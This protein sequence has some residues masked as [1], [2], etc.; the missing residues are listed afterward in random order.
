MQ[1]RG[2]TSVRPSMKA[3]DGW[4]GVSCASTGDAPWASWSPLGF[5]RLWWQTC[6]VTPDRVRACLFRSFFA[7]IKELL[8]LL[9]LLVLPRHRGNRL[10]LP[11]RV[12][13]PLQFVL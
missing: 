6:G 7:M 5:P 3:D 13:V 12:R 1:F 9:L 4:V 8:L 10:P 2:N 11:D